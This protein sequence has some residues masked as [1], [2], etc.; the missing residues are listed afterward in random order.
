MT[1]IMKSLVAFVFLTDVSP[2][3][4]VWNQSPACSGQLT[5]T[6]ASIIWKQC[7]LVSRPTRL[8]MSEHVERVHAQ[9][10]RPSPKVI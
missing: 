10:G 9:S 5:H 7:G 2:P 4:S 3:F 1:M 8:M 6:S